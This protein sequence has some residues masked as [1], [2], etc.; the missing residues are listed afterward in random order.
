MAGRGRFGFVLAI[1]GVVLI[2]WP[3]NG[4][5][6]LG[7]G[8]V[9]GDAVFMITGFS[10]AYYNV[11]GKALMDRHDPL[12]TT[13]A[14]GVVGTMGLL[15][16]AAFE[17]LAGYPVCFTWAAVGGVFYAGLLSTAV[18]FVALFWALGHVQATHAAVMM[19]LQPL[20]GVLIAWLLLDESLTTAFLIGAACVFV[21]VGMVSEQFFPN[22]VHLSDSN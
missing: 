20:A 22:R 15:P 7:L 8:R 18:G 21:G 3:E 6:A 4:R 9:V 14:A 5:E 19:Y 10:W 2:L 13:T 11:R 16:F 12:A 17:W 1:A